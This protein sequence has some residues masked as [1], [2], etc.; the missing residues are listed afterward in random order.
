[1][2]LRSNA[3]STQCKDVGVE[4]ASTDLSPEQEICDCI[5]LHLHDETLRH[6]VWLLV[7]LHNIYCRLRLPVPWRLS[8][9]DTDRYQSQFVLPI[10]QPD[11]CG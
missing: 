1:M 6:R 7:C 4:S 9:G 8:A 10:Y 5:P 11:C 2:Y 3:T